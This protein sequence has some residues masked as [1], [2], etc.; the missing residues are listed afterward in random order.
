ML[1]KSF[2]IQNYK[3][4]KDLEIELDE[5][6]LTP[7]IGLNETGKSTILQAIF[8]FD[9]YNDS[10]YNS[11]FINLDYIRNRY[12]D[13]ENPIIEAE[14]ENIEKEVLIENAVKK[15]LEEKRQIFKS[16]SIYKNEKNFN[17]TEYLKPIKEVLY[18]FIENIFSEI[19]DEGNLKIKREF[20]INTDGS[21]EKRYIIPELQVEELKKRIEVRG[22]G[23]ENINIIISQGEIEQLIGKSIISYLPHIIYIDDFKDAIPNEIED[24]DE[25]YSYIKEIFSKNNETIEKFKN[26][27]LATQDTI[28]EDIKYELNDTLAK[29]WDKMNESNKIK[30]EFKT[31]EI[32]LKYKEEKFQ[33]LINDLR[34]KRENGSSRKVVFPV[35]MRSKGFQWF[36]NFFIKMKYNWKHIDSESYGSIILL[37]EPGVYLHTNFQMELVNILKELSSENR[38]FYTTHLE[39]MV[40]PKVIKISQIKIAKRE[41]EKIKLEK[42]TKITENKNLG[43][44]TPV[45]NALKIDNFPLFYENKKV[46]LTEGMTDK[47]F[48]EMLKENNLLDRSIKIVPGSGVSNLET[49]ISLFI[50]ITDKYIVIFDNDKAGK[51]FIEKYKVRYGENES[52]KWLSHKSRNNK[53]D[54]VLEDYYNQ[55]MKDILS[56]YNNDIKTG[57]IDFYYSGTEEDKKIFYEE[58]KKLKKGKEDISILIDMI[59]SK[60]K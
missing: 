35:N 54:M 7:I 59:N 41:N 19:R 50:G 48:L 32:V 55:E 18:H 56:K 20:S 21:W 23:V 24:G 3:A 16:L 37:D 14:I 34:E 51:E 36:F 25:W 6:R 17:E 27:D 13:K 43:E 29:L 45:I 47:I 26:S 31:I 4:I 60:F 58:L 42:T 2:R 52:K 11:E 5:Q 39:N 57:L 1:Y 53:E 30:E 12:N 9:Y 49:L 15:I 33:F 46:I 38:I 40:N 28:I 44:I 10:Q 8:A 22:Y